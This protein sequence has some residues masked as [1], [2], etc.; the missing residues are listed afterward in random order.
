MGRMVNE[1]LLNRGRP[2]SLANNRAAVSG[3][4][5]TV[6]VSSDHLQQKRCPI[7]DGEHYRKMTRIFS[8]PQSVGQGADGLAFIDVMAC[9]GC[10][11][12]MAN[13]NTPAFVLDHGRLRS[14][15]ACGCECHEENFTVA[16]LSRLFTGGVKDQVVLRQVYFCARC[17][18]LFKTALAAEKE[19]KY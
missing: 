6:L 12:V 9:R 3:G 1:I 10:G 16:S 5:R 2:G 15:G 18:N 7:C 8:V 19:A 17:G 11:W 14:C 4:V 13:D